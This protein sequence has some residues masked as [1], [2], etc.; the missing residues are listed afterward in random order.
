MSI[1]LPVSLQ[2]DG[3]GASLQALQSHLQGFLAEYED[4]VAQARAQ[5]AHVEALL[6]SLPAEVPKAKAKKKETATAPAIVAPVIAEVPKA[7]TKGRKPKAAK[8]EA[9]PVATPVAK[10]KG[11]GHRRGSLTTRPAYEGLTLT[12]SIEKILNE[13]QGQAVNADDVV[14]ILYGD[15]SETVF[16]VAKERVTKN[17]SKGKGENR[18]KRVPNQLGYYTLSL[19][20]LK[21]VPTSTIKRGRAAAKAAAPAAKVEKAP[22]A[23]KAAKVSKAPKVAAK[24]TKTPKTTAKAVVTK[25][26]TKVKKSEAPVSKAIQPKKSGRSSSL[27]F[28]PLYQGNTL[29]DAIEKVLQERKGEFV[30]ADSVVKALYGDLSVENFRQA[31]DRVTKNLSKGKL[32]GKWERVPNQLGYYTL[33]MSAVKA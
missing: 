17:L 14:N 7:P 22:K 16:R 5:L 20:S 24:A 11:R 9:T 3:F 31:K 27:A 12:E 13:R 32:D 30:N 19:E 2:P 21:T 15:L 1:D 23:A 4:K 6:G 33:S 29:T 8:P 18:W 10:G 25:T 26:S 28:R